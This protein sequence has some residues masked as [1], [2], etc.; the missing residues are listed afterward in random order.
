LLPKIEIDESKC[1]TPFACKKCLQA[2]P[3]AVFVV[4]PR[5]VLRFEETNPH[6]PG[7]YHLFAVYRDKC[8]VCN[9]CVKVCPKG[10]IKITVPEGA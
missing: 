2:C 7:S 10:A 9:E 8:V 5:T 6:E 3:Q 4:G 1:L